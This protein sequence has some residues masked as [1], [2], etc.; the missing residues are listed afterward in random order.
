MEPRIM[1]ARL[2][3]LLAL[4]T[5]V[6]GLGAGL[7]DRTWKMGPTGWFTSGTLLA[8]LSLVALGDH[9]FSKKGEA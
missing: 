6:I 4:A 8:V 2:F 7:A 3:M 1:L 9:Y 5:G